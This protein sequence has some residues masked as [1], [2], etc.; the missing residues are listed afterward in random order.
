MKEG[1][2]E[3]RCAVLRMG[4]W[5]Q[6]M[7]MEAEKWIVDLS[8]EQMLTDPGDQTSRRKGRAWVENK[9]RISSL[10]D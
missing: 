6:T 9:S 8:T 4:T 7:I 2:G 3:T 10:G 1:T 5:N